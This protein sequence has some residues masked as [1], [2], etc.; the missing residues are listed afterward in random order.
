MPARSRRSYE[1][2][3]DIFGDWLTTDAGVEPPAVVEPDRQPLTAVVEPDRPPLT[4]KSINDARYDLAKSLVPYLTNDTKITSKILNTEADRAFG[5]SQAAGTYSSKDAYDA[6]ETAFNIYLLGTENSNWGDMDAAAATEKAAYLTKKI[7]ILPTQTRRDAEMDEFQQFSTPPALAFVVNWVANISKGDLVAEPSAGTGDL[8]VWSQISGAEIVLNELSPRRHA[9]LKA[10]FPSAQLFQENAEQLNNVLPPDLRPDVVLMNPPFSATAGR[11][12]GQRKTANAARHIEQALLRLKDGGRLVAVVGNG[13]AHG[14]PAFHHWWK[15]IEKKY[16]V[17]ADI[18]ISGDEYRKYGTTFDNQILVIDKTGPT[19]QPNVLNAVYSV[20]ELPKLLEGVKHELS[21]TTNAVPRTKPTLVESTGVEATEREPD[22]IPPRQ[23]TGGSVTDSRGTARRDGDDQ[24]SKRTR[25][26]DL[27]DAVVPGLGN[28]PDDRIGAGG[29]VSAES[30][31]RDGIGGGG[32]IGG[33]HRV[34]SRPDRRPVR[35]SVEKKHEEAAR[36]GGAE[37]DDE[38]FSKGSNRKVVIEGAQAHQALLVESAAMSEVDLPD[39][40]YRPLLYESIVSEGLLSE[41]QLEAVVYAGQAHEQHLPNGSRTGFFIGDGTG[42]GKGR[43][44][45][46][47]ILDNWLQG[48]TKAVWVS[49]SQG[50]MEDARRDYAALGEDPLLIFNHGK[51][52]A[53]D[54]IT[55]KEGILFTT[56]A[57]M[58]S[59]QKKQAN[60]LGQVAGKTRL[61][62]IQDWLGDDFDGVIAFDESHKMGN[63]TATGGV[64]GTKK[65]SAQAICGLELQRSLPDAR[66]LYVSATGA[67]ELSN[68]SYADRLGLWG[69][70]TP[71]IDNTTF[72]TEVGKGGIAAMELVSRDMKSLGMYISRSLSFVGVDYERL[73]HNLTTD[74]EEVYNALAGAWQTV[75]QNIDEALK[76][77]QA[78]KSPQA[79]SVAKSQFW[80]AH[81]RF[82]NQIITAMQT[83]TV[84]DDMRRQLDAGNVAVI[85]LVNTNEASQERIIANATANKTVLEELDFTP[86]ELLIDYVKGGF[87]V[88]AYAEVMDSDGKV[89]SEA[90]KDSEGNPVFDQEAIRMRDALLKDLEH[91]RVTENPLDM[92]INT[93]GP[94]QVAEVTGRKRRFVRID[95]DDGGYTVEEQKRSRGCFY[96]R[97]GGVSSGE[98]KYL[99]FLRGGWDGL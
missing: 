80:G 16:N 95:K 98:A 4:V 83:P 7:Q 73:D 75:L 84:I 78:A 96:E 48:R 57:T 14:R 62:Q 36:G 47:T 53:G 41:D 33:D 40:Y 58:R 81:Q 25:T 56:Y 88:V 12:Q 85:Q 74:Q 29:R 82:F 63:A 13:M 49:A 71:F 44:I 37:L 17:R 93:F 61:E 50:L 5:G 97:C 23:R 42:V 27:Q 45:S 43:E 69:E 34:P 89:S 10:T 28:V 15:T 3:E 91:I 32:D 64:R 72:I 9:L 39:P 30:D 2:Q 79:S 99:D 38:V 86:R 51:I 18:G 46:G 21:R 92:I 65:P 59:A 24:S 60:D 94:D 76:V 87:P 6:V 90:V 1:G 70:G 26:T 52:K 77:T 35:I 54:Q 20:S 8:A 68:L 67:T 55:Q 31:T 11:V 22:I 66:I 19:V